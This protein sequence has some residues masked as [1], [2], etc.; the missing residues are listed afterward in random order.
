MNIPTPPS[1]TKMRFD[2]ETFY[3]TGERRA[4][5]WLIISDER[6]GPP[7]GAMRDYEGQ[8]P[9]NGRCAVCPECGSDAIVLW[10]ADWYH[11]IA[12]CTERMCPGEIEFETSTTAE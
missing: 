1:G 5:G 8:S 7:N 10:G 11:D 6:Y 4:D 3:S 12:M 2:N 9:I